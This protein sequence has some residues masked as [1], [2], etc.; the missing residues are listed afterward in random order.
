MIHHHPTD[1]PVALL[2]FTAK[3]NLPTGGCAYGMLKNDSK[4]SIWWP[5]VRWPSMQ[6]SEMH[7]IG[8]G[9]ASVRWPLL[10]S[11]AYRHIT[12]PIAIIDN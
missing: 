9:F 4:W 11:T 8:D 5:G 6:P 10:I 3:R 1:E 2:K 12:H 7:T